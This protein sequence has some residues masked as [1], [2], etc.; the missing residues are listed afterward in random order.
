MNI[1][2]IADVHLGAEPDIGSAW[3]KERKADIQDTFQKIITRCREEKTDLLLIAGDLFHHPPL[4]RELKG[5]NYLFKSIPDTTVVLMA[6]NH[7]Y[8]KKD[9]F[10]EKF[11]WSENV[12][13]LWDSSCQ[14]IEIPRLNLA[15]YGCSYYGREILKPLYDDVRPE[16]SCRYHILVAHGGDSR[17]SPIDRRKV[18]AAGFDYVALGHIHK[19]EIIAENRMAYAGALE[20]VDCNDL[21]PHGYMKVTMRKEGVS[22]V[23]VPQ[24]ACQYKVLEVNVTEESTQYELENLVS[25]KIRKEGVRDIYHLY[26]KGMRDQGME[27]NLLRLMKKGRVVK[28]KDLTHP[29][30]DLD[31]LTRI[32]DGSLIGEYI[33]RLR[34]SDGIGEKALYYGLEALLEMKR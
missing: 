1:I 8:L 5:V 11:S 6:G 29:C 12:V 15:V 34:G 22:A 30:Y 25:E 33:R 14:R 16:G 18:L 32:Y 19:P 2:H 21:G 23:F 17:H 4:L 24:A 13:G 10:F 9:G 28:V 31:E 20:P 3:G 27:F 7:D 26:L